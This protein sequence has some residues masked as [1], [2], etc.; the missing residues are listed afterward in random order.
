VTGRWES[1][2]RRQ[3]RNLL[4]LAGLV[5]SVVATAVAL[6]L[7]LMLAR[8]AAGEA[9]TGRG[10]HETARG[11]FAANRWFATVE[12][13]IAAY[14]E[15]VASFRAGRYDDALTNFSAALRKVPLDQE[16]LVLH[17]IAVTRERLGDVAAAAETPAMGLYRS[18]REA[19][20]T[21]RCLEREDGPPGLVE[22]SR[23]LDE[24]LVAKIHD[25]I[26]QREREELARLT[27]PERER[28]VELEMRDDAAARREHRVKDYQDGRADPEEDYGW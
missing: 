11:S 27:P 3:R 12:H 20:V 4:L 17:N 10:E 9:A 8:Q 25:L 7:L 1:S 14:N 24:R 18:G 16:C 13:W 6:A 28:A 15:G 21:G 19:L 22:E 26:E 2:P 23:L 5:P